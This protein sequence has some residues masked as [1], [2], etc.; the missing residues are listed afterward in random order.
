MVHFTTVNICK[1][2]WIKGTLKEINPS[3]DHYNKSNYHKTYAQMVTENSSVQYNN[4]FMLA[5]GKSWC[6]QQHAMMELRWN[7]LAVC[8]YHT[9]AAATREY[10]TAYFC[11][12]VELVENK[13][14][15]KQEGI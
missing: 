10:L 12:F 8:L 3:T 2:F 13:A 15:L 1:I 5:A 6:F 7:G 11:R 9:A 4:V 14:E